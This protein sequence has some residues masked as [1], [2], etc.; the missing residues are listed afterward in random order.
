MN[1]ISAN[2]EIGYDQ[3]EQKELEERFQDELQQIMNIPL[4]DEEESFLDPATFSKVENDNPEIHV[5]QQNTS[6]ALYAGA[7]ITVSISIK[8]IMTFFIRHK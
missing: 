2:N 3:N 4:N 8:L 5:L 1:L 7:T 6:K